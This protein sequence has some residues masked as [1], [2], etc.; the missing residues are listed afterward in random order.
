MPLRTA[1]L[2]APSLDEGK[3]A[4]WARPPVAIGA[5]R[6]AVPVLV[7][8]PAALAGG[9]RAASPTKNDERSAKVVAMPLPAGKRSR[10]PPP[11]DLRA[12]FTSVTSETATGIVAASLLRDQVPDSAT[13][14]EDIEVAARA[15][16]D[17]EIREA[18]TD[19][20]PATSVAVPQ[21][22]TGELTL[23]GTLAPMVPNKSFKE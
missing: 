11:D 9:A 15:V 1:R 16:G 20:K 23:Q 2:V 14:A 7:T 21:S 5:L 12:V 17:L 6:E 22:S 3:A 4:A 18:E 10:K 8:E 13:V 19:A